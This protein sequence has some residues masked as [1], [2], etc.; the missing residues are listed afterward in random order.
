VIIPGFA[1]IL[2]EGWQAR[3]H[4]WPCARSSRDKMLTDL[5]ARLQHP[6]NGLTVVRNAR[7]FDSEKAVVGA[8]SDIYLLRGRITSIQPAGSPTRAWTT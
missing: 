6:L 4:R 2:E 1:N 5:A 7:I 3:R 8:L